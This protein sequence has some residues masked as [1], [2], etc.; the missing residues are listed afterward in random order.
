MSLYVSSLGKAQEGFGGLMQVILFEFC[1]FAQSRAG[2]HPKSKFTPELK[3]FNL[4]I[5]MI[6]AECTV[7]INFAKVK[8]YLKQ[9]FW[10]Y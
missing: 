7:L 2:A 4:P 9:K 1:P 3:V 8:S 5:Q 6:H 10:S